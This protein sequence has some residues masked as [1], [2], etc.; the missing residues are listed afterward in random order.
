V[1]KFVSHLRQVGSSLRFPPPI[2]LTTIPPWYNWN[3]ISFN[4]IS[5]NY[6]IIW[7][8]WNIVES[9]VKYHNPIVPS[10]NHQRFLSPSS[11]IGAFAVLR[12]RSWHRYKSDIY[13]ESASCVP[14]RLHAR[15]TRYTIVW[16]VQWLATGRYYS[17]F[18]HQ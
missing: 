17:D 15:C 6:I 18:L 3:I 8:N 2:K 16:Y 12:F 1:I 13:M 9:G 14:Q 4:I 7:Y 11:T 5:Y 10:Q